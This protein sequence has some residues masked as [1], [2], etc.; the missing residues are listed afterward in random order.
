MRSIVP[1][2][3]KTFLTERKD[4][5][6]LSIATLIWTALENR[7][8][9]AHIQDKDIRAVHQVLCSLL[10]AENKGALKVCLKVV[11]ILLCFKAHEL[12]GPQYRNRVVEYVN[13]NF[14]EDMEGQPL[15]ENA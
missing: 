12:F 11:S 7:S 15:L 3:P 14:I 1:S 4:H 9:P 8:P 13:N 2:V 10:K 6:T 5:K